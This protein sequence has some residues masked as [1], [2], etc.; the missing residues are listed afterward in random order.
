AAPVP[1]LKYRLIPER[2]DLIP[3]NAAVFYHRALQMVIETRYRL[4]L[5]AQAEKSPTRKPSVDESINDW[6]AGAIQDIPREEARKQLVT[7]RNAL[8]EVELGA[9]RDDCNWEFDLRDEGFALMLPDIQESRTLARLVA[10]KARLEILDGHPEEAIKWLRTGF[11]LGRH[12]AKGTSVIQSL[13]GLAIS[14]VMAGVAED[15]IQIPKSPNLYWALANLPRPLI[16]VSYGI[17]GE[18][19]MLE[20]EI[21]GLKDLGGEVWSLDR[22]RSFVDQLL[23]ELSLFNGIWGGARVDSPSAN[24]RLEEWNKRL[25]FAALVARAYPDAKLALI[26]RGRPAAQ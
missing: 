14:Q 26:A 8:R 12:V 25:I 11:V 22:A 20:R 10:L 6:V 17:E 3:G 24:P 5:Q 13:V 7:Y 19:F 9:R 4:L 18:R 15:L 2:R 16:D 1:A 21:P 23:P